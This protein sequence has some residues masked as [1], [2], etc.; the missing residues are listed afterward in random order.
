MPATLQLHA[1]IN[2]RCNFSILLK[3]QTYSHRDGI[4]HPNNRSLG[5][6]DQSRLKTYKTYIRC[7]M[8]IILLQCLSGQGKSSL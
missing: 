6:L 1:Q 5:K 4:F 8:C 2:N 3:K 7:N